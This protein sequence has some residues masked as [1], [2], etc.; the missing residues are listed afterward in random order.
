LSTITTK[1]PFIPPR[2]AIKGNTA[3]DIARVSSNPQP[4]TRLSTTDAAVS[5][6]Y[7]KVA[8]L[9]QSQ[10][11]PPLT[12]PPA[13]PS[14]QSKGVRIVQTSSLIDVSDFIVE[15]VLPVAGVLV[16]PDASKCNGRIYH[17]KNSKLSDA[18]FTLGSYAPHQTVDQ[19][20]PGNYSVPVEGGIQVASDG[21][22]WIV[23][24]RYKA[25]LY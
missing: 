1:P 17:L 10:P 11:A 9:S 7:D 20:D 16:L 12:L 14:S 22:S 23:I 3:R 18:A 8:G 5:D 6:L 2:D 4:F 25:S 19:Q 15:A 13:S 24:N 21:Q